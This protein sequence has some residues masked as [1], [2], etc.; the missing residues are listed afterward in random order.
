MVTTRRGYFSVVLS[1]VCLIVGCIEDSRGIA[2]RVQTA[3]DQRG[4]DDGF[5][6]GI[7]DNEDEYT[8]ARAQGV[9]KL[10]I[11]L[12]ERALSCGTSVDEA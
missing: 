9:S 7:F 8:D 4:P 11:R 3:C 10:L 5:F 1:V 12:S 2:R 6:A